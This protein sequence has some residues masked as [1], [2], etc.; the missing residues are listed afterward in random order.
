MKT[1]L[2]GSV[3]IVAMATST[4]AQQ[5]P[6]PTPPLMPQPPQAQPQPPAPPAPLPGADQ[7][8]VRFDIAISDEVAGTAPVRKA[9][10]VLVQAGGSGSLRAQGEVV[11]GSRFARALNVD[12]RLAPYVQT[13]GGRMRGR[14]AVEYQPAPSA[15]V[16]NSGP[17]IRAQVDAQFVDGKKLVLWQA[18]DPVSDRRTTVEVTA[19]LL[20]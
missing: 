5:R 10:M 4:L 12:I 15:G 20:K 19:T 11:G 8:N 13:E 17:G 2:V 9:V 3:F 18:A 7:P 14:V 1:L 6:T 16:D